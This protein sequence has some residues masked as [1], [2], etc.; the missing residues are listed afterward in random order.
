MLRIEDVHASYVIDGSRVEAVRGV[1]LVVDRGRFASLVGASGC[2]KSTLLRCIAGLERPARGRIEIDGATVFSARERVDCPPQ[3]RDIGMVFQS[4]AIWPHLTVAENV[5]FPLRNGRVTVPPSTLRDRV[6][7]ALHLV[8][9]E[10]MA[11]RPAPAL[12]GGQQQRVAL[13]RAVVARPRVLLLD[14]PLSNLDVRLREEMRE[15]LRALV[16]RLGLTTLYVTHDRSEALSLSDIVG[17]MADGALVEAD[18]PRALY[19]QPR[20]AL[21]A[22]TLGE[23]NLLPG[24]V[25]EASDHAA[26]V[27]T[28]F[29]RFRGRTRDSFAHGQ[30]A[31]VG[32][33]PEGI[34]VH[35]SDVDCD[36]AITAVVSDS[37]YFGDAVVHSLRVVA[38]DDG[39]EIRARSAPGPEIPRGTKVRIEFPVERCFVVR[40]G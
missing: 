9:L 18:E 21:G 26:V 27:Q 28:V 4:Y 32:C 15:Q 34:I 39:A 1:S 36:N 2:G 14:E 10:G 11:D 3:D 38:G 8:R 12:S 7:E 23:C 5:A 22:R 40:R 37:A 25:L 35:T 31:S 16:G 17:V 30:D 24:S 20:T 33:R 19:E 13:A 6:A 29:G